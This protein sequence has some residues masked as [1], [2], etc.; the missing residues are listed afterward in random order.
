MIAFVNCTTI[1]SEIQ[2]QC[3]NYYS[4][5]DSGQC[6]FIYAS[7][8]VYQAIG[9]RTSSRPF[10]RS[11]ESKATVRTICRR[12]STARAHPRY[13]ILNTKTSTTSSTDART[14]TNHDSDATNASIPSIFSTAMMTA[15]TTG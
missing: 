4:L 14:N 6:S 5:D 7:G 3:D 12:N 11:F 15:A 1:Q 9:T 10:F 2:S 8:N 13:T